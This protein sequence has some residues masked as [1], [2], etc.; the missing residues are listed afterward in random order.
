MQLRG[1]MEMA[2]ERPVTMDEAILEGLKRG[3]IG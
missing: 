2:L 3:G 1:Q